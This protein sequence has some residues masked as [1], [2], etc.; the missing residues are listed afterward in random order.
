[1]DSMGYDNNYDHFIL[2]GASLGLTQEKFPHWGEVALDHMD[3]GAFKKFYK[4][5]SQEQEIK[6]HHEHIQLTFNKL[7]KRF[8]NFNF[9]AF[10]MD[11]EGK[12]VEVEVDKKAAEIEI[13]EDISEHF[14]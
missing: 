7:S 5:E 14:L 12:F 13:K 6:L 8:P 11:L 4:V 3:C 10:L 1:M 2:A 9:R